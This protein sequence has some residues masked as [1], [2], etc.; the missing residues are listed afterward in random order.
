MPGSLVSTDR[1]FLCE[2][3]IEPGCEGNAEGLVL[4]PERA[5]VVQPSIGT[6]GGKVWFAKGKPHPGLDESLGP[7]TLVE[8]YD[9]LDLE[10]RKL[11]DGSSAKLPKNGRWFVEGPFQRSDVKNANK[12]VYPRAIWERLIADSNSYVQQT[13]KARGMLGHLEHPSDG[14]TDGSKGALVVTKA[15]LQK[16][17]VVWGEAELLDT[18]SGLIL[19]EYTR[20]NVRWGVS[21]RG[22]GQVK[23]DGTVEAEGFML[24]TWDAVMKPSVPGAYPALV[25]GERKD[26]SKSNTSARVVEGNEA[27]EFAALAKSLSETVT[28]GLD[29][30]SR[31][32]LICDLVRA[33]DR[34]STLV[35]K[36]TIEPDRAA[37]LQGW[38]TRKLLAVTE[39]GNSLEAAID[40]ALRLAESGEDDAKRDGFDRVLESLRQRLDDSVQEASQLRERLEAAESR[41]SALQ[42]QCDAMVEQLSEVEGRLDVATSKLKL[43]EDLLATRPTAQANGLVTAAVEEA[44]RQ[45]P[46]LESFRGA[47]ESSRSVE[48][49]TELAERLLPMAVRPT[50]TLSESTA[51]VPDAVVARRAS[52]PRGVVQSDDEGALKPSLPGVTR[53]SE[54]VQLVS[55]AMGAAAR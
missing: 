5:Y 32:T 45:V 55:A 17:G 26:E 31:T 49:V 50:S 22:N 23:D 21:S 38:L 33:M 44:I 16:D 18:P 34:G 6:S 19:Q 48:A 54:G 41:A 9:Q 30:A 4:Y 27:A 24:E 1:R 14:R 20:K 11:P 37:E 29:P 15:I 12:R 10:E 36:Q 51:P 39:V 3:W 42:G 53:L 25:A 46:D 40:E 8:T 28:E 2:G 47:L 7:I 52:L 13:I 43:A 35:S